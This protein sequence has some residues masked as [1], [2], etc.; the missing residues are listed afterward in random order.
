MIE[1]RPRYQIPS[2]NSFNWKHW[3]A[4]QQNRQEAEIAVRCALPRGLTK[5]TTRRH[6]EIISYR[7]SKCRDRA[8]FIAGCKSIIDALTSHGLLVDDSDTWA[9]FT[10]HQRVLSETPDR[11]P[12]TIIRIYEQDED[13]DYEM[14]EPAVIPKTKRQDFNLRKR[15]PK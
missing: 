5:A 1:L 12:A 10:Y 11:Q 13:T 9:R 3:R 15:D 14:Q 7:R 2:G 4:K 6:V 8:N